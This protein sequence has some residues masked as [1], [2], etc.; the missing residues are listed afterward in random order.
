MSRKEIILIV[1]HNILLLVR[2]CL[3]GV[4]L[5]FSGLTSFVTLLI[6]DRTMGVYTI[7]KMTLEV[8]GKYRFP[9]IEILGIGS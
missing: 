4:G 6:D 8:R 5:H 9:L 2:Y 1:L 3:L 7:H